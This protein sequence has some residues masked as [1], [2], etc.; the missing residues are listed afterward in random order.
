MAIID[1]VLSLRKM[2]KHHWLRLTRISFWFSLGMILGFFFF[3]SFLYIFY[4]KSHTN[5]VY[6]GVLVNGIDFGGKT[7]AQVRDYFISK[8]K[9]IQKTSI[10]LVAPDGSG[11]DQIMA[12]ISAKQI[13]FGY[14]ADLLA[15]Q[16]YSIGRSTD[17]LSNMSLIFQAYTDGVQLS[18]AYHFTDSKLS[19][20][21]KKLKS[22]LEVQPVD[23]MFSFENG[24]VTAFRSSKDGKTVDLQKLKQEISSNLVSSLL[25][26]SPQSI[27]IKVPLIT[28]TPNVSDDKA[29]KL[30]IKELIAEGTSLF[31]HSIENRLYNISLGASKINGTLI[32]PGQTF[33]FEKTVG[34]VSVD[35]GY[36]Q[37]YVIENGK[38]VLG[39]GGGIC[40]VSTTLFRAALNAGLPVVERHPHAYRVGYY[41]QDSPPG[42]DAAV[43]I[44]GVDLKFKNDTGHYILIQS[45]FDPD[46]QRLTF[47][48]YGTKDNREVTIDKPVVT[49]ETPAP[50]TKYEDDPT[51]PKGTLKQVDFSAPGANVYFTREVKKNGKLYLSDKFVSNYRPWQAIFLRGTKE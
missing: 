48:L 34:D 11:S 1:K 3:I 49:S 12:T 6:S 15:S 42:I 35:T 44:P 16:A 4:Q 26:K 7:Q 22:Q 25:A 51:L 18:P 14:D 39:D 13:D 32:P 47:A 50:E 2:K 21:I 38:T 20:L 9:S 27:R 33:S 46:E 45:Y 5:L 29:D 8:N 10:T 43:Y 31:Q 36:K 41:E 24:K 37:A 30:G 19:K 17:I 23:A 40:Q 28:V